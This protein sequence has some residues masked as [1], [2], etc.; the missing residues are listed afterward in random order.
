MSVFSQEVT[1]RRHEGTVDGFAR[2]F[3]MKKRG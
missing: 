2:Q 3:K 1:D